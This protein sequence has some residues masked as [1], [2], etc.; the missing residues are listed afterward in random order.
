ML[1]FSSTLVNNHDANS[2]QQVKFRQKMP[3]KALFLRK[4]RH[5]GRISLILFA[6]GR[7]SDN[8]G[9]IEQIRRSESQIQQFLSYISKLLARSGIR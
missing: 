4:K 6:N 5:F 1:I 7:F 8:R 9:K 3:E 2:P